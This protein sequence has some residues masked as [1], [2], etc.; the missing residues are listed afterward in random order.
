MKVYAKI[1]RSGVLH[2]KLL[3]IQQN[4]KISSDQKCTPIAEYTSGIKDNDKTR[5][6]SIS[7]VL[8]QEEDLATGQVGTI[9][10]NPVKKECHMTLYLN[11]KRYRKI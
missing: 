2:V 3:E 1:N 9:V 8:D 7:D 4:L 10:A 11:Q 5:Q 6:W